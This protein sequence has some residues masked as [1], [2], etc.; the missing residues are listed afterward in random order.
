MTVRLGQLVLIAPEPPAKCEACGK[1]DEL[2]PYG[3]NGQCICFACG[4]LDEKGT[5]ARMGVVLFGDKPK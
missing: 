2:R 3:P 5:A 4:M 1:V